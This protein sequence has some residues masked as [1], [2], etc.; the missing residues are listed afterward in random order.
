M[1]NREDSGF[2]GKAHKNNGFPITMQLK[3]KRHRMARITF[4]L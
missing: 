3:M 2:E 4:S 1:G